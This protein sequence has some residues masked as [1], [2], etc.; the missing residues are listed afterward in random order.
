MV[1]KKTL[2]AEKIEQLT[3]FNNENIL[4]LCATNKPWLLDP[5]VV[6]KFQRRYMAYQT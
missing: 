4:I 3:D 6:K 2:K 1:P 5:F